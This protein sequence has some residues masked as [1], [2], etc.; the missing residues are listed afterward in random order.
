MSFFFF[1]LQD[2]EKVVFGHFIFILLVMLF[3]PRSEFMEVWLH[4]PGEYVLN[5]FSE[6]PVSHSAQLQGV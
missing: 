6:L 5:T 3:V 1:N 2:S 4:P